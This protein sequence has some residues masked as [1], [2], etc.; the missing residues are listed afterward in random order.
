MKHSTTRNDPDLAIMREL[1]TDPHAKRIAI[2]TALIKLR[3]LEIA[4]TC[5]ECRDDALD[6]VDQVRRLYSVLPSKTSIEDVV[7]R[8][9]QDCRSGPSRLSASAHRDIVESIW[10][11][12]HSGRRWIS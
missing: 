6:I 11:L 12:L 8:C 1:V 4:R 2:A 7:D 9:L 10:D 5:P 3:A